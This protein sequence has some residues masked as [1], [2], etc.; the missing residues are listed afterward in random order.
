MSEFFFFCSEEKVNS[1]RFPAGNLELYPHPQQNQG[2]VVYLQFLAV[3]TIKGSF[4]I[5]INCVFSFV[6][7]FII[8][9]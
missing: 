9:C 8:V 2:N 5:Q 4:H 1:S 3:I 7:I 6:Q